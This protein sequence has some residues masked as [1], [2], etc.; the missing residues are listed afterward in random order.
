MF[1]AAVGISTVRRFC[2]RQIQDLYST[3][4]IFNKERLSVRRLTCQTSETAT[5]LEN[6]VRHRVSQLEKQLEDEKA[7][8]RR[9]TSSSYYEVRRQTNSVIRLTVIQNIIPVR[10]C[11]RLE[12]SDIRETY[13]QTIVRQMKDRIGVTKETISNAESQTTDNNDSVR[14]MTSLDLVRRMTTSD[15]NVRRQ[16]VRRLTTERSDTVRVRQEVRRHT[17]SSLTCSGTTINL[18]GSI[19]DIKNWRLELPNI[20]HLEIDTFSS[21]VAITNITGAFAILCFAISILLSYWGVKMVEFLK[22]ENRFPSLAKFI[23]LRNSVQMYLIVIQIIL[24]FFLLFG[25][26]FLNLLVILP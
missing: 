9:L 7:V 20:E 16:T 6:A 17:S 12:M 11:E 21:Y 15:T 18:V 14:R 23:I 26:I 2:V 13:G 25:I 4:S 1:A 8:R 19:Q 22:L 10:H 5:Q 24:I 3:R